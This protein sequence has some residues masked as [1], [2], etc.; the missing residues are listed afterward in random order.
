MNKLELKLEAEKQMMPVKPF[1]DV[2]E[3][4]D[5]LA[6]D[7]ESIQSLK[8]FLIVKDASHEKEMIM[9]S[10][11]QAD[12]FA[13]LSMSFYERGNRSVSPNLER[14]NSIYLQ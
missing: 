3:S 5:L 2:A 9:N 8:S 6:S 14:Y 4:E 1:G 11:P 10:R 13:H 12:F 7:C